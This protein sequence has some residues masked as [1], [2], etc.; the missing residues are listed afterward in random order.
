MVKRMSGL[1]KGMSPLC[2]PAK[3]ASVSELHSPAARTKVYRRGYHARMITPPAVFGHEF[4][5][6]LL[7]WPVPPADWKTG[8]RVVA[9][10]S[11]PAESA[12]EKSSTQPR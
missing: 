9:A 2:S 11:A 3:C 1:K 8:D 7:R 12:L 6:R 5:A 4:A 10:N